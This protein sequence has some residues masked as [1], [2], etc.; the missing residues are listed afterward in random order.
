MTEDSDFKRLVRRRM[1]ETG[2]NYTA[3]R[4]AL[5]PQ[6]ATA[7]PAAGS[8]DAAPNRASGVAAYRA[9][10]PSLTSDDLLML[11]TMGLTPAAFAALRGVLPDEEID[12]L[13]GAHVMELSA[14]TIR[15]WRAIDHQMDLDTMLG[16]HTMELT[17]ERYRE[18]L[19]S[20][21][22]V[23]VEQAWEWVSAGLEP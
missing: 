6:A 17:P 20:S 18:Y 3:A 21:P 12:T 23:T 15:A 16:S 10:D 2:E 7:P 1:V 5:R 14:D 22:G 13:V 9:V 19:A 8:T 11:A 4:A